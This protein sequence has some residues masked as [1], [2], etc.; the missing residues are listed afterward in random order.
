MEF[1]TAIRTV[2][3]GDMLSP[4]AT[5]MVV[6]RYLAAASP[7]RPHATPREMD[8]LTPRE[9]EMA[10][11]LTNYEIAERLFVSPLTVSTP[12]GERRGGSGLRGGGPELPQHP[13][14]GRPPTRSVACSAEQ[15]DDQVEFSTGD[16]G[17]NLVVG[18]GPEVPAHP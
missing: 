5:H 16:G 6:S 1:L 18:V 11:G 15:T 12:P 14:P 13:L 2:A 8:S 10:E 17:L 7:D 3:A 4:L 9:Q